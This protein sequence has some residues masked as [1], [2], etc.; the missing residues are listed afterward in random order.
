MEA[1]GV[2]R[3]AS[4]KRATLN[5]LEIAANGVTAASILL[6]GRNN[7][8]TWWTGI[9]GCA[10]F[11]VVFLDSRLYADTILQVFFIVLSAIGW[12]QWLHGRRGDP[13]P[14]SS[15]PRLRVLWQLLAGIAG[16]LAYGV[17]LHRFTNA[18]APFLDSTVLAFSIVAQLLMMRR[19]V[20]CWPFWLLVNSIAVPL[21]ASRGLYLTSVLYA[22]YWINAM[23]S[24]RHWRRLQR[25]EPV[26]A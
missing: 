25:M 12:W 13:L 4:R 10:L 20:Q 14:V 26:A 6:A 15:L 16:A 23:V 17:L 2:A 24:W 18:Y 9:V 22:A 19:R 1:G 8:H 7:M 11:A 3:D 21:Y 5:A